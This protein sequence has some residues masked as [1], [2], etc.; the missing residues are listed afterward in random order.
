[1]GTTRIKVIDLSSDQEEIKT[2]RKHAEKLTGIAKVRDKGAKAPKVAQAPKVTEKPEEEPI[3][4]PISQIN[5]EV[6][7][8]QESTPRESLIKPKAATIRPK[9]TTAKKKRTRGKK[10]Q[11]ALKLIDKNKSYTITEAIELLAKTSTT[12]FDPTVEVHLNVNDKNI[13]GKINFPHA[14]GGKVKEKKYLI[15]ADKQA[16]AEGNIIWGNESTITD[17]ESG[18]LKAGRDFDTVIT[19]PKF[20]PH[21]VK[22]AKILGPKGMMPN[23]KAGNITDDPTAEITTDSDG[24]YEFRTDPT[25]PIIHT[26]IGKLSDKSE[27]LAENLKVLIAAVGPTK[28]RKVILKSTMSPA[29][30]LDPSS[31]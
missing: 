22:I 7:Q 8:T 2:S 28:I 11:E 15:F 21:L 6:T 12:S 25:A 16:K 10:Y 27:A 18:K 3:T 23:P 31:I 17:I 1:M 13:R 29:I 26:K 30:K 4:E 24:A 14:T 19:T 5:T 20:M 9:T